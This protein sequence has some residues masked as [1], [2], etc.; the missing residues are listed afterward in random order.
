MDRRFVRR[1]LKEVLDSLPCSIRELARRSGVPHSTLIMA[2]GG[3]INLTPEATGKV[4]AALTELAQQS[5]EE[6]KEFDRLAKLMATAD[7]RESQGG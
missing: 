6:A 2:R 3:R 7:K 1:A 4:T 5:R